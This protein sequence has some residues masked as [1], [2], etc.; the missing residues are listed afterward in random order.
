MPAVISGDQGTN[1]YGRDESERAATTSRS[2]RLRISC[3]WSII[4]DSAVKQ[5]ESR[6]VRFCM[7]RL[8]GMFYVY[9]D[10][11]LAFSI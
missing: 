2:K 10:I 9:H 8:S 5:S 1:R 4:V 11:I 6:A 7:E 3:S